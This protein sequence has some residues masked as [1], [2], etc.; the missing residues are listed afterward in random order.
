ML[1]SNPP[2]PGQARARPCRPPALRRHRLLSPPT[3]ACTSAVKAF[4]A[5][6]LKKRPCAS[7]LTQPSVT[8]TRSGLLAE[9]PTRNTD[10]VVMAQRRRRE[11]QRNKR[12]ALSGLAGMAA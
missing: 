10:A 7:A 1:M 4:A 12:I 11:Q 5:S 8:N 2:D 3:S 9:R 6:L